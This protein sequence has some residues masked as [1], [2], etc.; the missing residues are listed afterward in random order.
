MPDAATAVTVRCSIKAGIRTCHSRVLLA[1]L[2]RQDAEAN[3]EAGP[4]GK[5]RDDARHPV[6]FALDSR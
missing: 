2:R 3:G 1:G 5:R 4:K 6:P